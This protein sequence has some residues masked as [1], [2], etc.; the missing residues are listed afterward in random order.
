MRALDRASQAEI[1]SSHVQIRPS[2]VPMQA[3]QALV[4]T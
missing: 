3:L 2:H 4:A 1:R